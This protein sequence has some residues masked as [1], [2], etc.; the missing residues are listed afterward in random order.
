MLFHTLDFALFLALVW[1]AALLLRR[2]RQQNLLLLVA[3]YFFYGW[4]EWRYVPLLMVSTGVDFVVARAIEK[5]S[6]VARRRRLLGVSLAANLGMLG[7]FKYW[8]FFAA[9]SNGLATWLG[10]GDVLP[11]LHWLLPIGISFY[12]FQ[13]M[14]Y[15]IDVYRGQIPASRSLVEFATFISFFPQLVAGPIERARNLLRAIAAPRRI[16]LVAIEAG[17]FLFAQ[18]WLLKSVADVLGTVADPI[19][20]SPKEQGAWM[21][22]WGAYAFIFQIYCDFFG[23]SQMARGV[24]RCFGISLMENFRAPFFAPNVRELW[25]RWHVSLTSWLR[26]Y[27]FYPLG[28]TGRGRARLLLNL[29]VVMLLAG[30]WHG[31]GWNYVLWGAGFGLILVGHELLSGGAGARRST[32]PRSALRLALGCFASFHAFTL[33]GVMFRAQVG[34]GGSAVAQGIAHLSGLGGLFASEWQ[35]PPLAL[36]WIVLVWLFDVLQL[37]AGTSSWSSTW[38]WPA[39]GFAIAGMLVAAVILAGP[40]TRS[41]IYFQF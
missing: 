28:G 20:A 16:D 5:T 18:G 7:F 36:G 37:R 38:P 2:T 21:L 10:A 8:D 31:A 17:V 26:D 9:S 3:S 13:S 6:D 11:E 27:V 23:Y 22:L 14:A 1:P 40:E 32:S 4:W 41:F 35:S 25:A 30:L 12:T 15:T 39:R 33:A 34:S 24:A 19:F 29:F